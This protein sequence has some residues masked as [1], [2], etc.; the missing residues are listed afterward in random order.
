MDGRWRRWLCFLASEGKSCAQKTNPRSRDAGLSGSVAVLGC[1]PHIRDPA[2]PVSGCSGTCPCAGGR[3]VPAGGYRCHGD[4]GSPDADGLLAGGG[5]GTG[6]GPR[7]GGGGR[8]GRGGGFWGGR[9]Q[10]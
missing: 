10:T 9:Q 8:G 3:A 7:R 6:G 1:L 5:A 4:R 2:V